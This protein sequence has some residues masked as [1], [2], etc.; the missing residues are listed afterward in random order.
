MLDVFENKYGEVG[1]G[2]E[3]SLAKRAEAESAFPDNATGRGHLGFG[4][5]TTPTSSGF[6]D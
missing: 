1:S 4:Y 3:R 2:H 6:P 5:R